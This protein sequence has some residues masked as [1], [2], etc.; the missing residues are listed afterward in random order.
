MIWL[1]VVINEPPHDKTN[2]MAC[3]LSKDSDQPGHPPSLIRVF[4]VRMK[5]AW[6]LSHPLSAQ[7]RLWSDWADA[8][9]DLSLRWAHMSSCW[10]CHEAAEIQSSLNYQFQAW[11]P[12]SVT[13][14]WI[15]QMLHT[16][17]AQRRRRNDVTGR[18]LVMKPPFRSG[19]FS[20]SPSWNKQP[21]YPCSIYIH[22]F[23]G[24]ET[25]LAYIKLFYHVA[26]SKRQLS[27][28]SELFLLNKMPCFSAY[29]KY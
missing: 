16:W 17:M 9:A 13:R 20:L 10:F 23:M 22:Y 15:R 6:V 7:G 28:F 26:L 5:K 1:N 3:A 19:A 12:A 24:G 4:A 27:L 11:T 29:L 25:H 8:Q 2:K 21:S 18:N 14:V